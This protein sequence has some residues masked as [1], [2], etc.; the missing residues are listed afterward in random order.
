MLALFCLASSI[1]GTAGLV[2]PASGAPPAGPSTAHPA[3]TLV[4]QTPW[5]TP[6]ASGAP[7]VLTLHLGTSGSAVAGAE[8]QVTVYDR[9]T[10]RSEF[11][12]TLNW[13]PS[14]LATHV[15]VLDPATN[16]V[17]TLELPL[18]VG[19]KQVAAAK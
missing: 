7:G 3:L 6:S 16:R 19:G 11:E 17:G 13:T 14:E 1:L 5:V 9:L 18:K 4:D 2:N 15:G 12:G 8:V 10:T